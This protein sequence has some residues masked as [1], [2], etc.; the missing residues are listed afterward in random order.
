MPLYRAGTYIAG[1]TDVAVADGGTGASTAPA[2]M[3][4]LGYAFLQ[5]AAD[6]TLVSQTASQAIFIVPTLAPTGAITLATGIYRIDA[7]IYLTSMSA[8][9]GNGDFDLK[10]GGDATITQQLD[11]RWGR[12]SSAN[13]ATAANAGVAA[14][15]QNTV[16]SD[17]VT[18]ATSTNMFLSVRGMFKITGAGTIIPSFALTTAAAAVVE[19]NSW[20]EIIRRSDSATNLLGAWS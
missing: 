6:L 18:A 20:I 3:V 1:G 14:H 16:G 5:R 12:D 19:E 11:H 17:N 4:N 15:N 7:M 2:A 10:G 13:T 8:T 9:S